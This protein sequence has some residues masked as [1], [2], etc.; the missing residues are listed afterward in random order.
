MVCFYPVL[1]WSLFNSLV[2]IS[3]RLLSFELI[4]LVMYGVSLIVSF[5]RM[6]ISWLYLIAPF[7]LSFPWSLS[8]TILFLYILYMVSYCLLFFSFSPMSFTLG[9][10]NNIYTPRNRYTYFNMVFQSC[11]DVFQFCL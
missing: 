5:H 11:L 10:H 3:N 2:C 1:P 7:V 6:V 4:W 9:L 8:F